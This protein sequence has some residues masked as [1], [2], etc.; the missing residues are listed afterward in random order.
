MNTRRSVPL[1]AVALLAVV[2][3]IVPWMIISVAAPAGADDILDSRQL[4]E[5]AR[6]TLEGFMRARETEGFRSLAHNARGIFIA[7]QILRGAFVVGGSGGSGVFLAR[8]MATNRWS[9]PAFYTLGG[10]S[11]GFQIGGDASEVIFLAM[12]DRGVSALLGSGV[13]LGADVGVAVGPIGAGVDASTANLSVDI[14]TFSRSKGLYG[15]ISLAGSVVWVREDWNK[16]YYGLNVTPSDILV[17]RTVTNPLS[18]GLIEALTKAT[19][20]KTVESPPK[21]QV[22]VPPGKTSG[23]DGS[24]AVEDISEP[25][26]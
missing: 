26:K 8:D 2:I 4:V 23:S 1:Q 17:S 21:P 19:A 20:G 6:M 5:K 13:K 9:G 10:V 18:E 11:F 16:A 7:P 15:G 3:F 24:V 12:T 25:K 22:A 14:L